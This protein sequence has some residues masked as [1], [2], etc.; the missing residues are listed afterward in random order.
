M[1]VQAARVATPT[2]VVEEDSPQTQ[3][4]KRK[5]KLES[6]NLNQPRNKFQRTELLKNLPSEQGI[7]KKDIKFEEKFSTVSPRS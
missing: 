4:R 7:K 6:D 2:N 5:R 1:E 3:K